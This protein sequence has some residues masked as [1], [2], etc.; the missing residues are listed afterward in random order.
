M[1]VE[2]EL[3]EEDM[4]EEDDEEEDDEELDVPSRSRPRLAMSV[5]TA[6]RSGRCCSRIFLHLALILGRPLQ[7][8][9]HTLGKEAVDAKFWVT[10]TVTSRFKMAC[11]QPPGTNTVSPGPCRGTSHASPKAMQL[12]IVENYRQAIES[13]KATHDE[14][15]LSI[16]EQIMFF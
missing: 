13:V 3:V 8:C 10:A 2:S 7:V 4:D 1:E 16:L 5:T 6:R 14:H 11:H 15:S 9:A 12:L